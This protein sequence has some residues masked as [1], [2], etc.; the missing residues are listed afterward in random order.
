MSD[1]YRTFYAMKNRLGGTKITPRDKL[2]AHRLHIC[3]G[4][5]YHNHPR[6]GILFNQRIQFGH[7]CYVMYWR[8]HPQE[9]KETQL[10]LRHNRRFKV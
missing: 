4:N 8:A 3:P 2:L 10:N 1:I 7:P 5:V 6:R 9:Y